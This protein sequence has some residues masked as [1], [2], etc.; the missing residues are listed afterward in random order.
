MNTQVN[1]Y[2]NLI[3]VDEDM[4]SDDIRTLMDNLEIL[5]E[6]K[7]KQEIEETEEDEQDRETSL[8]ILNW[9]AC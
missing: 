4:D 3:E 5:A 9:Y 1:Y 2:Y 6:I 7:E 8:E